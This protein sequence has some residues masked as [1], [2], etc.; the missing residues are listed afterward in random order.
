MSKAAS[1]RATLTA[2]LARETE[3]RFRRQPIPP[4]LGFAQA[5]VWLPLSTNK[6]LVTEQSP[7]A[8]SRGWLLAAA[9][10]SMECNR[11][12]GKGRGTAY[13]T[14]AHAHPRGTHA[15]PPSVGT[16][17]WLIL[18]TPALLPPTHAHPEGVDLLLVLFDRVD[19]DEGDARVV[20]DED[21]GELRVARV[22]LDERALA[23]EGGELVGDVLRE[24][25][26]VELPAAVGAA[27]TVVPEDL[28]VELQ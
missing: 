24:E 18:A 11:L 28:G 1:T 6:R 4:P 15:W 10:T 3:Q 12:S 19:A 2:R 13:P 5:S 26:H 7:A 16:L 14:V 9:A 27:E 8:Q 20:E 23:A 22:E 17:L 21:L 25:A